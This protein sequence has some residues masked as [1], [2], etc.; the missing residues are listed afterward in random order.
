MNLD[1]RQHPALLEHIVDTLLVGIFTVDAQ[2][3]FVAWNR[4]AERITGYSQQDML[5]Q[6]CSLL[7]GANCKGFAALTA[8]MHA[9]SHWG[10]WLLHGRQFARPGP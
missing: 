7:E 6:P 1:F 5:G 9:A 4:G 10:S 2:G 8:L 3:C